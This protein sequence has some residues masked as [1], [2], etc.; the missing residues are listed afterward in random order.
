MS[1]VKDYFQ[2]GDVFRYFFRVFRKPTGEH[3]TSGN[4]RIMHG[5]NRISIVLFLICLAVMLFR[6]F[7]R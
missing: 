7:T 5:I 6:A 4:L 2:I 3:P 1:N